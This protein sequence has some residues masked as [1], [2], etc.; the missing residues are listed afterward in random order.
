MEKSH[1]LFYAYTKAWNSSIVATLIQLCPSPL[2]EF[3]LFPPII[4]N[5]ELSSVD[6]D[7]EARV[8]SIASPPIVQV[9]DNDKEEE[10]N[11]IGEYLRNIDSLLKDGISIDQKDT[12][13]EKEV[14][15]AE[16]EVVAE[17]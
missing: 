14:V 11:D 13:V 12:I 17:E 16:E 3:P 6:D 10:S 7:L 5:Y 4:Q 8:R 2:P 9:S 1:N 15:V